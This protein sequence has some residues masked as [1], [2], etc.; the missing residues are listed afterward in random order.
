[1]HLAGT[2]A[3]HLRD[4][5]HLRQHLSPERAAAVLEQVQLRARAASRFNRAELM[6]FT[7]IGLQQSTHPAVAAHHAERFRGY[8][9]VTDLGCGLG[10]DTLA[11]AGVVDHV[12][13]IDRD[14]LRL[15]FARHN[16]RAHDLQHR[17]T[18]I[19]AD[20]LVPPLWMHRLPSF[21]DPGRRTMTGQRTFKP[22]DYDPPLPMLWKRMKGAN[23]MAI[24]AAPGIPHNAF[25]W[26]DEVE[27]IS[28]HGKVKE[29]MLWL[30]E[31]AT[32]G[33]H[34]RATILP[35]GVTATD[36]EPGDG[37]PVK[38]VGRFLYE[39]DAAVIRAGLVQ[40]V[41]TLLG[42]WQLD[43]R[44][45]YL[46][47][48]GAVV[49]PFVQGFEVDEALP[50]SLKTIRQRL[51]E[52]GV[53]ILEIKMRGVALDPDVFRRQLK[54]RGNE[55]RTLIVT[56]IGDRPVAYICRRKQTREVTET[57]HV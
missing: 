23:G 41:A 2:P 52:L 5:E 18:I 27:I 8:P 30:G 37:C 19:Q 17:V 9:M 14:P 25:P 1:M 32:P 10:G 48:D 46:S 42:L 20:I 49:S 44:I 31:L 40:Q 21:S 29:A 51:R 24:K 33:V 7:D 11:L 47:G 22:E 35:A 15:L 57:S 16:I 13:A 28:L 6:L 36:A 38:P 53:R 4:L 39:P 12:V 54:L 50:F 45:A 34:R 43:R 26:L 55:S 56:R 3:S